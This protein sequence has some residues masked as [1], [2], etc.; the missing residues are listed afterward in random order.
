MV[1][2]D[3]RRRHLS[4]RKEGS[5]R[6]SPALLVVPFVRNGFNRLPA[7]MG[8]PRYQGNTVTLLLF[9]PNISINSPILTGSFQMP[10]Q[11]V[12]QMRTS[13]TEIYFENIGADDMKGR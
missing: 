2:G 7:P 13:F 10:V 8:L 5:G 3:A 6:T 4:A 9:Q 11:T 12:V 1:P